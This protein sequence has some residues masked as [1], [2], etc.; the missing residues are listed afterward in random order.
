[1]FINLPNRENI[2]Q[3]FDLRYMVFCRQLNLPLYPITSDM[4]PKHAILN[5]DCIFMCGAAL[6]FAF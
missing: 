4:I 5:I 3:I 2:K 6:L 1:M